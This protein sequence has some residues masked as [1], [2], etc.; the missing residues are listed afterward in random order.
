VSRGESSEPGPNGSPVAAPAAGSARPATVAGGAPR[1]SRD[2]ATASSDSIGGSSGSAAL[3]RLRICWVL[4]GTGL[5]GGVKSTRLLAEAM[6]SRGHE[7]TIAYPRSGPPWPSPLHVGSFARRAMKAWRAMGGETPHHLETSTARLIPVNGRDVLPR[8]VPDADVVIGTWWETM[9]WLRHWPAEKGVKAHFVR[10]HEI[11]GGDPDRVRAIYRLPIQKFAIARWLQ[12]V[13][14]EQY[15]HPDTVLVPN[16]V[17]WTQFNSEPRGKQS[18][19]TVGMLYSH[20]TWKDSDTAFAAIRIAQKAVPDLRVLAFGN[21]PLLPTHDLPKNV[22]FF[23]RPP[24][25]QIPQIYRRADC[26]IVSSITEGFGMPGLESAACRCP[27]VSTRCGGPEDYVNDASSGYLV[28][29]GDA[30][31]M[32]RRIVDVVSQEDADWRKMSEASYAIARTFNWQRSAEILEHALLGMLA[33]S[34]APAVT[35]AT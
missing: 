21:K 13:M 31:E 32:A 10:H 14:A 35:V 12:R 29:V 24:Q 11:F 33:A 4:P 19:P 22:E 20:V 18:T 7:V 6:V 28:P 5:S 8:H 23:L 16:G 15:G 2:S 3:R 25:D 26:W 34:P 27:V 17:D 30:K 9:E 1:P